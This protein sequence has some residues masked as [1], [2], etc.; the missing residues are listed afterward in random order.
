MR[1]LSLCTAVCAFLAVSA[2]NAEPAAA[3][4]A[5]SPSVAEVAGPPPGDE[6]G[7][8]D[9]IDPGDSALRMVARGALVVPKL[10]LELTLSPVRGL[11][12]ADDRYDLSTL[13]Y[14]TFFN[15]DRTIGLFPTATYE[16]GFGFSAGA[17]FED[18]DVFGAHDSL[19]VQATTGAVS[20]ETYREGLLASVNTGDRLSRRV[21][22]ELDAN[23]DRRPSDPF[24]GIG[25]G[26]LVMQPAS[27]ID[28][29]VNATAVDT[30]HRYQEEQIALSAE[31]QPVG[32]LHV[33][34]KGELTQL[35]FEPGTEGP[36][37]DQ[38]YDPAGLVGF[39][40]GVRHA[41]GELEVRWDSRRRASVWEPRD[42][43]AAGSLAAAFIGR[44]DGL[45]GAADFWRYGV[46]LQHDWEIAKGPRVLALRFHGEG[47]TGSL[48]QVPFAE[49]PALG[50][51][52]F[53]RGYPFLRFRDRVAAVGSVQ[54]EWALS[55]IVDAYLF[56]DAG[57][58]F[59][60]LDSVT[61]AGMR[62]GY[63]IG[64]DLHGDDG[65]F[66]AEASLASSIDG[67]V[68]LTLSF[69]PALDARPRWR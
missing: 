48:D 21:R 22:L 50:G 44:V 29:R 42:V 47:V 35:R 46:E 1:R 34:A 20:G 26:D 25:N 32:D 24:Y 66:E 63:G 10:A 30:S 15:V 59:S 67:G 13:Y 65:A 40:T 62:V 36:P 12:W 23:F 37:I 53:L 7:R 16:S 45:D 64:L 3:P 43:H 52:P 5:G 2:A 55:H 38:V 31:V 49:L 58:V 11:V 54:Y 51:S 17:R 27:P 56:S 18:R 14:R 57:R 9:P 60:S 68:Y 28:P 19:A 6:S 61:P 41:Y 69:N 4:S 8:A 33:L 39:Q